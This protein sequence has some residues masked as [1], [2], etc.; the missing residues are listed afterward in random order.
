MSEIINQ[1]WLKGGAVCIEEGVGS[2]EFEGSSTARKKGEEEDKREE[3]NRGIK[4]S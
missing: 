3:D 4:R 1:N 2:I